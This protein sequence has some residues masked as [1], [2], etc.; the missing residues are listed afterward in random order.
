M[1]TP[2]PQQLCQEEQLI[3]IWPDQQQLMTV[4]PPQLLTVEQ[5][6]I[7]SQLEQLLIFQ[8]PA[9]LQTYIQT[10]QLTCR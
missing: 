3:S 7:F 10:V 1:A 9:L 2:Q 6:R 8:L 5:L 4:P